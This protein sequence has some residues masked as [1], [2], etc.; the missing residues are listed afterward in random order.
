MLHLVAPNECRRFEINKNRTII[1]LCEGRL[2]QPKTRKGSQARIGGRGNDNV[3]LSFKFDAK[4]LLFNNVPEFWQQ[5]STLRRQ[6]RTFY[7]RSVQTKHNWRS[8][9]FRKLYTTDSVFFSQNKRGNILL[10][11]S[12]N[13]SLTSP[14]F[15]RLSSFQDSELNYAWLSQIVFESRYNAGRFFGAHVGK[16][17]R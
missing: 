17:H 5:M 2:S 7:D 12:D 10:M 16:W 1:I 15:P 13:R 3:I 11:S 14:L 4:L 8:G 9:E 6:K